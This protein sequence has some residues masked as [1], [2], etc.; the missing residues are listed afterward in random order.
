MLLAELVFHVLILLYM[1][2]IARNVYAHHQ[3]LTFKTTD[4][5]LV[6]LDKSGILIHSNVKAAHQV[7]LYS[8]MDNV[9]L[10]LLEHSII[11]LLS[12]A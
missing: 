1:M 12:N 4:V 8:L 9:L 7:H 11:Q 10:V 2:S 6:D 5:L 3:H